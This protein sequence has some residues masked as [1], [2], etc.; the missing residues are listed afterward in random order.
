M[1]R[2]HR[3]RSRTA[4][5]GAGAPRE[6]QDT[7]L[8]AIGKV[9]RPFGLKGQILIESLTDF[10]ERFSPDQVLIIRG[11]PRVVAA[12]RRKK[13]HWILKL[14]GIDTPDGA[15]ELRDEPL[16]IRASDLHPLPPGQHYRFQLLGLKVYTTGGEYLGD[17]SEVLATGSN[18]VYVVTG[19]G[20]EL[21]VPALVDVVRDVNVD[22]GK[23]VVQMP[24]GSV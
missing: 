1:S 3:N 21:L 9:I 12:S 20:K 22:G 8:V 2:P 4:R 11:R 14:E 10:P 15:E 19:T 13:D 7:R 23:M 16:H 17:I 18:D 6:A 5:R 24:E